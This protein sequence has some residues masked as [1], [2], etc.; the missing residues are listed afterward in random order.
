MSEAHIRPRELRALRSNPGP[1]GYEMMTLVQGPIDEG[2]DCDNTFVAPGRPEDPL[3]NVTIAV[4]HQ[5]NNPHGGPPVFNEPVIAVAAVAGT[6]GGWSCRATAT[7][8]VSAPPAP[9]CTGSSSSGSVSVRADGSGN[10]VRDNNITSTATGTGLESNRGSAGKNKENGPTEYRQKATATN[11]GGQADNK[12]IS[13]AGKSRYCRTRGRSASSRGRE[14]SLA[15]S[16]S[17][18][19]GSPGQNW[20]PRGHHPSKGRTT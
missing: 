9:A 15:G 7:S 16:S 12:S 8:G 6:S 1:L 19:P 17:K 5:N 20:D 3:A 10:L 18:H 2:D 4:D 13:A 11:A 14:R